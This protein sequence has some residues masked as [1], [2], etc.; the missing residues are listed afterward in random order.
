MSLLMTTWAPCAYT[1]HH[2]HEQRGPSPSSPSI[3]SLSL[4]T[5]A[6]WRNRRLPSCTPR[7]AAGRR[8]YASVDQAASSSSGN[9]RQ[10][11]VP[12][13]VE[14]SIEQ[15]L[16]ACKQARRDGLTRLQ[17]ELLLPLIGA[18][19]LDDWP[20][21]IQQQFKAAMPVVSSLFGGL[22]DGQDPAQ[23]NVINN[24]ILD[25]GDAVGVWESKKVALVLFPNA[26][27]LEK[28]KSLD[29]INNDRPLL[30]VNP[31]WQGGQVISDFGFGAQRKS[32][33][34]FVASF[35]T[36]Y[37]LKQLRILGEDVRVLK[38]YPGN[39][40]VFV[41]DS[42]GS[43]DCIAV[44]EDRPSYNKLQDLLRSREG[45]KAGQNWF[46]RLLGELKFNQDSLKGD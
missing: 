39:W 23:E 6:P 38:C 18:T 27:C 2:E 16:S 25:D 36:V 24:Y 26:D 31:Q 8:P 29:S 43:S 5:I 7:L 19:D 40:Q 17:L 32:R 12:S 37:Y 15:A 22:I 35:N 3:C 46:G 42:R 10:F 9:P 1:T 45:S 34:E 4:P 33:E 21:G 44:E 20:G 11:S 41:V 14:E 28:I 13:T 30:L